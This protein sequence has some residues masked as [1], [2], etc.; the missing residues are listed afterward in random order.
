MLDKKI[1][2]V[3]MFVIFIGIVFLIHGI[4]GFHFEKPSSEISFLG[5]GIDPPLINKDS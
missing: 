3:F 1:N 5:L 4:W 2:L